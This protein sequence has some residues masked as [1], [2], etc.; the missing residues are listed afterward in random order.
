MPYAEGRTYN[1]ADSHFMETR[2]WLFEYAD[3]KVRGKLKPI[4]FTM[5]GGQAT[6]DLVDA[7][8][9]IIER[10]RK[11]AAA[12]AR[13]E[14]NIL[15]RK[16]WHALGGYDPQERKRALDLLGYNRQLVF[17]GVA[18]QQFWG[19][20]GV[21]QVFDPEA[22]YGGARAHN[23][24]IAD[25]CRHDR[26]M[27]AVGFVPLDFPEMAVREIEQG[28]REGIAAFY[29]A[30][31]SRHGPGMDQTAGTRRALRAAPGRRAAV[32]ARRVFEER[33]G[34]RDRTAGRQ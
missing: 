23:R 11:D 17:T 32:F 16:S 21:Q 25:F 5:A 13:A 27:R 12:M 24:G 10:R 2:D 26:R 18:M 7:V 34:N 33:Q 9:S 19:N 31:P 6:A 15:E 4:D 28:V 1:D 3:P 8:P 14:A 20:L 29:V 22:L 30:H